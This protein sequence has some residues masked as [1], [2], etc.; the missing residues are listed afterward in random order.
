MSESTMP[1]EEQMRTQMFKTMV[2][3][4]KAATSFTDYFDGFGDT[5]PK[6]PGV[7][8][9]VSAYSALRAICKSCQG[10][11]KFEDYTRQFNSPE[12]TCTCDFVLLDNID[13]PPDVR[14]IYIAIHAARAC[15]PIVACPR[16][17]RPSVVNDPTKLCSSCLRSA[18]NMNWKNANNADYFFKGNVVVTGDLLVKG[19]HSSVESRS[20]P[21][22]MQS[23]LEDIRKQIADHR[24]AIAI[25][26][27]FAQFK[28]S[29]FG[30]K[31]DRAVQRL[32][33][34]KS[35]SCV[36]TGWVARDEQC[37]QCSTSGYLKA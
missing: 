10:V 16:C 37:K 23:E 6:A 26:S 8:Q 11:V 9:P 36:G 2:A 13:V 25:L 15:P 1:S 19:E 34:L 4:E 20:V 3:L 31:P 18:Q 24:K 5:P 29:F 30:T 21:G 35:C 17:K 22:P 14:A 33:G 32:V 7:E 12:D 28:D 27:T